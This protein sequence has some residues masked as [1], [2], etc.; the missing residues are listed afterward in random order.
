MFRK[1]ASVTDG[2]CDLVIHPPSA[3][4]C[5]FAEVGL[6]KSESDSKWIAPILLKHTKRWRWKRQLLLRAALASTSA[7]LR[8]GYFARFSSGLSLSC[9]SEGVY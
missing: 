5:Q 2:P 6:T 3:I 8:H 7:T 9:S 1:C 4:N